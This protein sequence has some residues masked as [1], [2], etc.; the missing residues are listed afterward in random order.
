MVELE[1]A[2][3][4]ETCSF[5]NRLERRSQRCSLFLNAQTTLVTHRNDTKRLLHERC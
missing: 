5:Q 1:G 4:N 2:F 3:G